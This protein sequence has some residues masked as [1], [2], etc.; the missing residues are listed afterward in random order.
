MLGQRY[1]DIDQYLLEAPYIRMQMINL[2]SSVFH[3]KYVCFFLSTKKS[4]E[5]LPYVPFYLCFLG[6]SR[7]ID[8]VLFHE[9]PVLGL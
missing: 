6:S 8:N 4:F 3:G 5:N 9:L 7:G 1:Y 2:H